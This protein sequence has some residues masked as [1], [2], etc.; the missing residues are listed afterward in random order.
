M[1]SCFDRLACRLGFH[2]WRTTGQV[3]GD[4][5]TNEPLGRGMHLEDYPA[6]TQEC[7]HCG[8]TRFV[9]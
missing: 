4:F 2:Q 1:T 8:E 3:R 6:R 7:R 5:T 9:L